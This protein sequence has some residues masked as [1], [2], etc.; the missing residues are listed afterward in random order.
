MTKFERLKS[1]CEWVPVIFF[2]GVLTKK[3]LFMLSMKVNTLNE[4]YYPSSVF[5]CTRFIV[6]FKEMALKKM[7]E[8]V[9][10]TTGRNRGPKK[11]SAENLYKLLKEENCPWNFTNVKQYLSIARSYPHEALKY[12]ERL[13]CEFD[14][15]IS[16]YFNKDNSESKEAVQQ[17]FT[18][19]ITLCTVSFMTRDSIAKYL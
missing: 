6:H 1:G 16:D 13:E 11:I 4:K 8:E 18:E 14:S 5:V 9:Y 10:A 17:H 15:D 12:A 7:C 19:A 2:V 3:E